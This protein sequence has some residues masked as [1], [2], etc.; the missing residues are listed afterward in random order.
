MQKIKSHQIHET[1]TH[2]RLP[3]VNKNEIINCILLENVVDFS[4]FKNHGI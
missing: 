1:A 2:T 4:S 3:Y